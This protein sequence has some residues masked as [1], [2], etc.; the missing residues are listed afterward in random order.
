MFEAGAKAKYHYLFFSFCH[1][2][3]SAIIGGYLVALTV[4][5][6]IGSSIKYSLL[7]IAYRLFVPG[8][9]QACLQLPFQVK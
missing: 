1:I 9:D 8:Y 2:I 4:D 3:S 5:F 6:L 7:N